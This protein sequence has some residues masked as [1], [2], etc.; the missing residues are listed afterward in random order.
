MSDAEELAFG[1][2]EPSI[3]YVPRPGGYAVVFRGAD[4]VAVVE[5]PSGVYLPGGGQ[6]AGEAPEDAARREA[7]EEC[8]LIVAIELAVGCADE[9]VFC[10]SRRVHYRKVCSFFTARVVAEDGEAVED[11]HRLLWLTAEDALRTLSHGSQR[12]AVGEAVRR[13]SARR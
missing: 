13:R 4:E 9:F 2:R 3:D 7:V 8:G 5:T 1:P 10:T 12:W 11:D 6:D